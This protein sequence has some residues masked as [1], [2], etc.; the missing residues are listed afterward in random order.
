VDTVQRQRGRTEDRRHDTGREVEGEG[1]G[2]DAG[3]EGGEGS[4][5]DIII[6]NERHEAERAGG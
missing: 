3:R 4:R 5:Y 6:A 2:D 1:S